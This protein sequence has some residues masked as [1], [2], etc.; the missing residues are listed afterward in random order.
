MHNPQRLVEI[1]KSKRE[2]TIRELTKHTASRVLCSLS[3]SLAAT[4]LNKG[5]FLFRIKEVSAK[6]G[7][8]AL[9]LSCGKP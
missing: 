5:G 4:S 1:C 6:Q 2:L 3:V 8:E 9:R 7:G